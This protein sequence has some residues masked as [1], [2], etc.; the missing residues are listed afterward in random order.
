MSNITMSSI[1]EN[2]SSG[3]APSL[4]RQV[5]EL[6]ATPGVYLM[7]D[8]RSEVLYIG[9]AKNLRSRVRSYFQARRSDRLYVEHMV[10]RVTRVDHVVTANEK[11][12]LILENNLIKQFKPRFNIN[13][14]DDKTYVSIKIETAHKFPRPVVVRRRKKEKDAVYFGPFSSASSVRSTLRYL[15]RLFPLRECSDYVIEHRSRPCQL[16][17]MGRCIAPCVD[18]CSEP[19]YREL[20]DEVIMVLKGHNEQ[21]IEKLNSKMTEAAQSLK[22]E[23]AG[24]YRDQIQAI[25]HIAERQRIE[26]S[27]F[28]DRDI[29]AFHAQGQYVEIQ[30]MFVRRGRLEDLANY[31]FKTADRSAG[32]VFQ[33]F[34]N[35]F[36]TDIRMIPDEILLPIEIVDTGAL[37]E[38]L[39]EQRSKKVSILCPKRGHKARLVELARVNAENAYQTRYGKP[40]A[41]RQVLHS[42]QSDL[43]LSNFPSRIE[44]Y[45]ISNIGGR[46]AVGSMVTFAE[47]APDKQNYRHYK[48]RTVQQSD[49]FGMMGEVLRRRFT[50]GV[51]KNDLPDLVIIDGGKGQLGV[52]QQVFDELGVKNVDLI[53]LAKSRRRNRA[54]QGA[55]VTD[56]RVFKPSRS[57]PIVLPQ[58]S[59][60][61]L[62]LTRV[63][64]EAHRFAITYHRKLR[65]N[66][67]RN[68]G[69]T[70][71]P[72]IGDVLR[73]RLL[74][75][76]G[77]LKAIREA[78]IN[79]L[80][81][82]DGISH[83]LAGQIRG[84]FDPEAQV[85]LLS[86]AEELDNPSNKSDA[87]QS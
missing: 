3:T 17:E 29:F 51:G 8:D 73:R 63:R 76:F 22:F 11:E 77:T 80:A 36:Y 14:K 4:D 62:Y 46:M 35:L 21:L 34:L 87:S 12:A 49:D 60:H 58:D 66:E 25:R 67:Y 19:E 72:G 5:A 74:R 41:N 43:N 64:D 15:N 86:D 39:T 45:D 1:S 75:Q 55:V 59:P 31:N 13:L 6:P 79:E 47:C 9:K 71:I 69:L 24:R 70:S 30:A 57:E 20:V 56:E 18:K 28:D 78:S 83:R 84:H 81:E 53:G 10:P 16:Y 54:E 48:I 33:S 7:K 23:D 50:R 44:C 82:V 32:E 27:D 65:Q 38:F 40:E 61:L 85:G 52:A 68:R 26:S 2:P 42:L 37:S